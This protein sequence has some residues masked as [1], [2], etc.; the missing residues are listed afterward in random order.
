MKAMQDAERFGGAF[1]RFDFVL[2]GTQANTQQAQQSGV[3]IDQQN[4]TFRLS[5][6]DWHS[7]QDQIMSNGVYN[8]T[9]GSWHSPNIKYSG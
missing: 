4:F 9:A 1:Y 2:L 5:I 3:V 8:G 6:S 7:S